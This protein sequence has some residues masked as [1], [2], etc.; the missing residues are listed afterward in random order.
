[1]ANK[2]LDAVITFLNEA[3]KLNGNTLKFLLEQNIYFNIPKE[4]VTN[5]KFILNPQQGDSEKYN[6]SSLGLLNTIVFELIGE[7]I[8]V[9]TDSKGQ[10]MGFQIYV[11]PTK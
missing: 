5:S 3:V 1:M 10:L 4:N 9:T 6:L 8:A 2:K 7:K 11:E